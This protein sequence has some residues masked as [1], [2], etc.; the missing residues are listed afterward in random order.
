MKTIDILSVLRG[1]LLRA[2]SKIALS[3]SCGMVPLN[4]LAPFASFSSM[5]GK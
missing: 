4:I 5:V 1:I 3:G 2:F